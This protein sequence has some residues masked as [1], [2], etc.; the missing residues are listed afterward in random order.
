MKELS[1]IVAVLE[2][3][4][5]VRR[6]LLHLERILT[7]ECELILVDDGSMPPLRAI[8]DA[9]KKS[10]DFT[11]HCTNDRRPWTQ[12]RAR[13]IAAKLA[14]APRLL[15]FDIDH[16]VTRSVL[17]EC[18]RYAGDKLHWTRRPGVL[19][20]EGAI[21]TDRE[22]LLEH[23]LAAQG[24]GVHA[25]SFMIR[26]ELFKRLGGYD[27]RFCGRYGGDDID[28]NARFEELCRRGQAKPADV[29]GEGFFYPDPAVDKALFHSLKRYL[30]RVPPR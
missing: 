8:C 20:A 11:L 21:V 4:E 9:V 29:A 5:V 2:S 17:L 23:G 7:P 30:E 6:Q 18:L 28:F 3:H 13:N 10:F 27:E 25:N 12:P 14:H 15:F 1:L 16:I 22:V 24:P 26:A 19:N